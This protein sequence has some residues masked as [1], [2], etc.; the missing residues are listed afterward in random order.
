MYGLVNQAIQ[1]LVTRKAG[2]AGW[3]RVRED[4]GVAD[5]VFIGAEPYPDELTAR[6]V[7]G[8]ARALEVEPGAFLVS[9]G[10]HWV[11]ETA[12]KHYGPLMRAGG[13]SM[14]TFLEHLPQLHTRVG[15]MLP[16]LR[17]PG[18][19]I[20]ERRE[21]A[22][23]LHYSSGREGLEPFVRGLL[24]GLAVHFGVNLVLRERAPAA[25]VPGERAVFDLSW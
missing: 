6:L 2:E 9:L 3:R 10:E 22:L 24:R 14:Q 23:R 21:R 19:R 15:L 1:E 8:A 16:A 13:D 11:L 17:P 4:A 18:F 7:A 5:E 20:S 25:D 12:L